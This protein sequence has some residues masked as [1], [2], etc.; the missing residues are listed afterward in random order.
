MTAK[1]NKQI[2]DSFSNNL[3][4]QEA[5]K[6][7][8]NIKNLYPEIEEIVA[9]AKKLRAKSDLPTIISPTFSLAKASLELVQSATSNQDDLDLLWKT[10]KRHSVLLAK[11]R[12]LYIGQS[13]S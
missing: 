13:I 8:G 6:Y 3:Q 7:Q 4:S 10:L 11:L 9:K 2:I 12:I 5:N 1:Q